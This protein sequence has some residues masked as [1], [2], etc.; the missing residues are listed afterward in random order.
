M[1]FFRAGTYDLFLT[2]GW[3]YTDEWQGMVALIDE[4]L[5]GKWRNWSI[6]WYDTSI[7]RFSEDGKAALEKLL[8]GH[9][10]MAS[11]IL[12]LP[13]GGNTS[14]G[15]MWLNRQ[16][17]IAAR[18][19]KPIIGV[20]SQSNGTFPDHLK[21]HVSRIVSRDAREIISAVDQLV[22]STAV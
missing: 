9:I 16:L 2:H 10:S 3:Y 19:S 13:E 17:T 21:N 4:Y 1:G 5:P 12:L 22:S 8:D 14:D 20:L 6:P 15:R 11:A 7:D 18:C